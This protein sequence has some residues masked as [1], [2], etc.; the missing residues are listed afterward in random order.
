M[1]RRKGFTLIE[2]LTVVA[3]IA[4]LIG[5]MIPSLT[6]ARRT[7][8]KTATKAALKSIDTGCEM[9]HNDFRDYPPSSRRDDSVAWFD[10]PEENGGP[11]NRMF[12]SGTHLVARAMLGVDL[13]GID[14]KVNGLKDYN[15]IAGG[16]GIPSVEYRQLERK[17]T[18]IEVKESIYSFDSDY[19][20]SSY[21]DY[22]AGNRIVLTDTFG[23]PILYYKAN[24][25]RPDPFGEIEGGVYALADNASITGGKS[26]DGATENDHRGW[27]FAEVKSAQTIGPL[28]P[29]GVFGDIHTKGSFVCSLHMPDVVCQIGEVMTKNKESFILYSA[30]HDG[31]YGTSDDVDNYFK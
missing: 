5:I 20:D 27:D 7:A 12:L 18:Y 29:M 14:Y 9:F 30:G 3:I 8:K 24:Y 15:E 23:G 19:S 13:K 1:F 25:R 26:K 11:L 10:N 6:K 16:G 21:D 22:D 31:L 4:L 28:H 17:G 2:L